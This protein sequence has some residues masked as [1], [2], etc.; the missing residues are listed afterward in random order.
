MYAGAS[1]VALTHRRMTLRGAEPAVAF[2]AW[3]VGARRARAGR[4]RC[5]RA[6]RARRAPPAG[7]SPSPL[8]A[9]APN[10]PHRCAAMDGYAVVAAATRQRRAARRASYLRIDTGQPIDDRFDAVA[11]VEIAREG[12]AGLVARAGAR[13]RGRTC[14]LRARTC[15]RAML[16]CPPA[17]CSRPTTSRSPPSP[18]TRELRG[19]AASAR[20]RSCRRAGSCGLQAPA[21]RPARSPTPTGPMLQAL[22]RD[23]RGGLPSGCRRGRTTSPR[24]A[25]PCC[26]AARDERSGARD[27]RLLTRPRRPHRLGAGAPGE[28]VAHGVALRPAHPV[29]LGRGG[30]DAGDRHPR[31]PG[32]RRGG[33]RALR[34]G[35]CSSCCSAR[36]PR[37][38]R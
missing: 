19:D 33:L 34:A 16:C 36:C 7:C 13:R 23:L 1:R 2:E 15:R 26:D 10:P 17:V 32:R 22:A 8:V 20:S 38:R 11:Q 21:W 30:G 37:T 18:A 6:G 31:L 3:L 35:R 27:R 9:L 12:A 5:R 25:R 24:S 29:A 4:R 14:A 28:L